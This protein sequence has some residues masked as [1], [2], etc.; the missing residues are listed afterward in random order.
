MYM[1]PFAQ[2]MDMLSNLLKKLNEVGGTIIG[3]IKSA[4]LVAG[5]A[6]RKSRRRKA[7][8]LRV[9]AA[10]VAPPPGARHA[11]GSADARRGRRARGRSRVARELRP[12]AVL[13]ALPLPRPRTVTLP[14]LAA[15]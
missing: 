7:R 13:P 15:G 11:G 5:T 9:R 10:E 12:E 2:T 14:V 3:N 8:A 6:S 1:E 4:P